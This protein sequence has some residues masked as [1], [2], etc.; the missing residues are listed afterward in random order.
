MFVYQPA[1]LLIGGWLQILQA[2]VTSTFGTIV[3]AS[4]LEGWAFTRMGKVDRI[5]MGIAGLLCIYPE[6]YSDLVGIVVAF[7]LLMRNF[8]KIIVE[9]SISHKAPKFLTN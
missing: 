2:L 7:I 3:L 4:A 6:T 5:L 8:K 1:L 9:I